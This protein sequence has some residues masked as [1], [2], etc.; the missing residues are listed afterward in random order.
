MARLKLLGTSAFQ[1]IQ[2]V[3]RVFG[4]GVPLI[5]M[6]TNGEITPFQTTEKF[7]KPYLLNESIVILAIG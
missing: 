3:T 7:K 4:A 5:G 6:Y 1:E 2:N